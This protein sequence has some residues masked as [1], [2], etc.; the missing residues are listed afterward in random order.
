MTTTSIIINVLLAATV[1][2]VIV[3]L[4][5][6]AIVSSRPRRPRPARRAPRPAPVA[7]RTAR[8]PRDIPAR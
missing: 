5:S 6:W 8:R 4:C 7:P 3:G 1:L 2:G